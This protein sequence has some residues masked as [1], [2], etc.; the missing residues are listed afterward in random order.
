VKV[1]IVGAGLFA[2]G[3]AMPGV[4]LSKTAEMSGVFDVNTAAARDAADHHGIAAFDSL[5]ALIASRPDLVYL[6]TPP[7]SHVALLE[8]AIGAGLNVLCEKPMCLSPEDVETALAKAE[9]RGL[10]HAVDHEW[11]FTSAYKTLRKMMREETLGDICT[12][13]LSVNTNFGFW[14]GSPSYYAGFATLLAESGG[15]MPQVL[16]HYC[17]LFEYIFGGLE[18]AGAAL[19]TMVPYKPKARDDDTPG[20]IDAED[21]CALCGFLPNGAPVSISATWS[22]KLPAGTQWTIAGSKQTV[23]YRTGDVMNGGKLG[24][25]KPDLT[26]A[27][28]EQLPEYNPLVLGDDRAPAYNHGLF[29][30][31]IEDIAAALAGGRREG[32]FATFRDELAVRRNIA[33]WRAD[34]IRVVGGANARAAV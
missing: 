25:V 31:E 27:P 18:A 16:S 7:R 10:L 12:V 33:R 6:S 19:A 32:D 20:F 14:E 15:L 17:D 9:A 1:A 4:T 22:A 2:R 11:R 23:V 34:G 26:L 5:D 21:S 3:V 8:A 28:V 30:A 13:N 29:A 24:L